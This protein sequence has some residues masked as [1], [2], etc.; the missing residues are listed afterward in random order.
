MKENYDFKLGDVVEDLITGFK[1]VIVV[2]LRYLYNQDR[3]GLMSR[4]LHDGRPI[5][6]LFFDG[7]SLRFIEHMDIEVPEFPVI[8]INLSDEVKDK[9][10]EYRGTIVGYGYWI[11]GCVRLGVQSKELNREGHPVE[12]QWL[13]MDQVDVIK[14][15]EKISSSEKAEKKGLLPPGGPM[16]NPTYV[17]DPK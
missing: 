3:F 4:D 11:N 2:R 12:E 1:G 14:K 10:S 16:R 8:E 17:K 5:E 6:P 9:V 13:P 15:G 7:T